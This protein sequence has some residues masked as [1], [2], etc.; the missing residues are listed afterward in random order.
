[1]YIPKYFEITD[2]Q[3][4]YEIIENYSF[5][6]MFSQHNGNPYATHLPLILNKKENAL[7]GHFA[8]PNKQWQDIE[9]QQV[10]IIFQGP[11]CYISPSWYETGDAVPTW[12]Y[13][14]VH[15]YGTLEFIKDEKLVMES[16]N[17][18]V[19]KYESPD[20]PYNMNDANPDLIKGL[21]KGI[22][23]F[24]INISNIEAKAKLSQNHSTDRKRLVIEKL[25]NSTH[26][27]ER[28]IASLMRKNV[29]DD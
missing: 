15:V 29:G 10:L 1:M 8:L 7:Y 11:H 2:D 14:S 17:N 4:I 21:T 16:L 22:V 18:L 9:D 6:T 25:E 23:P 20:S 26:E 12:N 13:V 28:K 3:I 24:K 5:A 27:N 19:N